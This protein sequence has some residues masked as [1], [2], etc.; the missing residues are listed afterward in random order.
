MKNLVF[1][2]VIS[3]LVCVSFN[4]SAQETDVDDGFKPAL[5][6]IDVQK[7]FIGMM[8]QGAISEPVEYINAYIAAFK[9]LGF[10]VI[11]IY[12]TSDEYG[13]PVGSEGYQ[14][15]DEISMGDDATKVTKTYGNAFNKT[16]LDSTLKE[17]DCNTI[18]LCGLSA[19]G[20]VYSTYVGGK[21]LD[22]NTFVLKNAVMSHDQKVT[23]MIEEI[24]DAVGPNAMQLIFEN[25]H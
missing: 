1:V 3:I 12:H 24:V 22:Y 20:C 14:F 4:I 13:V 10:P 18:F 7:A 16:E 15:V 17:L 19:S 25:L 21:D 9:Q 6:V 23:K 5:I 8:D 11:Y 2:T